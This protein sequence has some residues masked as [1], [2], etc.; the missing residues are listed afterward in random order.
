MDA[1]LKSLCDEPVFSA[2]FNEYSETLFR[3]LY[4]KT[5]EESLAQDLTQE[6]FVRL[7]HHC[8]NV[9]I[10]TAKGYVFK[11]ANNLLLNHHQHQKVRLKFQQKAK[12]TSPQD[13]MHPEFLMQEAELKET[14]EAAI[15]NLPEKQRI[16]FLLSRMERKT[17]AEIAELL[18]I[19]R[20]AVEKRIYAALK[21]LRQVAKNIP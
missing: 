14:L 3:F 1:P 15:S 12:E 7:W 20:Q 2:V 17:Y 9:D 6:A 16:A 13:G 5:G 18:G 19:S 11:T 10:D 21:T 4:Y 8:A